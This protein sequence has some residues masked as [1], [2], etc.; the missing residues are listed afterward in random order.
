MK[1][2]AAVILLVGCHSARPAAAPVIPPSPVAHHEH[3]P[4][5]ADLAGPMVHPL[6][7]LVVSGPPCEAPPIADPRPLPMPSP[8]EPGDVLGRRRGI[9]FV[10]TQIDRCG[11]NLPR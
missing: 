1:R 9:L 6:A 8:R 10:G 2:A 5:R 11:R 4:G 3:A 7:E